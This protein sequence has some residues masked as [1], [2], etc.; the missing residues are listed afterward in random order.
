MAVNGERCLKSLTLRYCEYGGSSAGMREFLSAGTHNKFQESHPFLTVN[1]VF[2]Q[3]HTSFKGN[4]HPGVVAEYVVN[5]L[6]TTQQ[7]SVRNYT[8]QEILDTLIFL[9]NKRPQKR[10]WTEKHRHTTK[11][12]SI[13][14]VWHPEQ[15]LPVFQI[16]PD[17]LEINKE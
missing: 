6:T 3:R 13:Q 14:G 2:A 15:W 11:T 10:R 17:P 9:V 5:G 1:E 4:R 8:P 16:P 7:V 12:P